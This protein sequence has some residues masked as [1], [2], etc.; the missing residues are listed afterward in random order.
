MLQK[1]SKCIGHNV[2]CLTAVHILFEGSCTHMYFLNVRD[3]KFYLLCIQA[4]HM[5]GVSAIRT[6]S[7]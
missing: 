1:H 4:G 7:K 6:V 3:K 5:F 2:S